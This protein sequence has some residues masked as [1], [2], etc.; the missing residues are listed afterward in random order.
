MAG[1][2]E[3][4]NIKHKKDRADAKKGKI[5][6]KLAKEIL[7]AA[8]NGGADL[9]FNPRLRMAIDKAKAVNMP[10]D[11]IERAVK[12]GTGELAGEEYV[13]IRYEGYGPGGVAF[14][15]DAVTDNKNRTAP[16]MRNLFSR[17]G[18]NLGETGAVGWMFERKGLII[19]SNDAA[20]EDKI[21][22]AALD[23]GAEDI[24]T[25]ERYEVVCQPGD[26]DNVKKAIEDAG[27]KYESADITMVSSNNVMITDK[28]QAEK[29]LKLFDAID[30]HDDVQE[31]YANFELSEEILNSLQ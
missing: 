15:I 11:N 7:I 5:F 13:E 14:V 25:G 29:L 19:I 17:N 24:K 18:G 12:K 2:S 9:N 26:F 8:K 28:E 31:V 30:E 27:I 10:K 4:S 21:M 3:Y 1:H 6:T 16:E 20:T 23:A 22:E